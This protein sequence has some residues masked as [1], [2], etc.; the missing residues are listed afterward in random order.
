MHCP[1]PYNHV[2]PVVFVFF[3]L[4]WVLYFYIK[5]IDVHGHAIV[6]SD[7]SWIS[8]YLVPMKLFYLSFYLLATRHILPIQSSYSSLLLLHPSD[9]ITHLGHHWFCA[10][11]CLCLYSSWDQQFVLIF[12]SQIVLNLFHWFSLKASQ[13]YNAIIRIRTL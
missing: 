2:L 1:G 3:H 4:F 6:V 8:S 7:V 5:C 12:F 11:D 9:C 10:R 13:E